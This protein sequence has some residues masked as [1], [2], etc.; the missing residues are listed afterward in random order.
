MFTD[1]CFTH[2]LHS[3]MVLFGLRMTTI[4]FCL[5]LFEQ[6][7]QMDSSIVELLDRHFGSE[8]YLQTL[9]IYQRCPTVI[10]DPLIVERNQRSGLMN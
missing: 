3:R 7:S 10:P 6:V 5:T 2:V 1:S 4:V 9:D 8:R